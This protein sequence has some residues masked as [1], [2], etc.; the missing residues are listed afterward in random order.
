MTVKVN[1][2]SKDGKTYK[3]ELENFENLIGKSIGDKIQGNEVSPDLSGYKLEIKGTSDEAGFPGMKGITGSGL[4]KA[5][6]SEGFSMHK[7]KKGHNTTKGL[8]L[9]KTV[10]GELI[11]ERTAQINTTVLTQGG[12]KME[13]VFPEQNQPKE[14]EKKPAEEKVEE[15]KEEKPVEKEKPKEEVKEESPK[16]EKE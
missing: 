7:P 1:I 11:S 6:L 15:V 4:S 2:S 16:E 5:L 12:K 8:R 14:N 9:R 10:I 13:E 3:V